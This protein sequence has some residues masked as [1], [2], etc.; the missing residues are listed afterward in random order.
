MPH[1]TPSRIAIGLAGLLLATASLA[2]RDADRPARPTSLPAA[3]AASTTAT[4][5]P[6]PVT[7]ADARRCPTTIPCHVGPP[8]V[9]PDDFFGWGS[10]HGNDKL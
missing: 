8:G 1:Q 6:R 10:S 2:A 7:L 5:P 4:S 3:T 9:S